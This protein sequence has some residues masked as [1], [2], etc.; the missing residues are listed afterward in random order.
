MTKDK[1]KVIKFPRREVSVEVSVTDAHVVKGIIDVLAL[2]V[3]DERIDEDVRKEYE[4]RIVGIV[5]K[6]R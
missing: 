6:D 1:G 5:K 3:K 4:Q 2:L